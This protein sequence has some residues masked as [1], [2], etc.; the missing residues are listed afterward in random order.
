MNFKV[1][2]VRLFR[3]Y[4]PSLLEN[5]FSHLTTSRVHALL[6]LLYSY[7]GRAVVFFVH[8]HF[9]PNDLNPIILCVTTSAQMYLTRNTHIVTLRLR[10][11][12]CVCSTFITSNCV[13]PQTCYRIQ[14]RRHPRLF[15]DTFGAHAW[16]VNLS[17]M[18]VYGSIHGCRQTYPRGI[19]TGCLSLCVHSILVAYKPAVCVE[20]KVPQD[21][22]VRFS[23]TAVAA[24]WCRAL[25]CGGQ[26]VFHACTPLPCINT[27]GQ[28]RICL[29]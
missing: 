19:R 24:A 17:G 15:H 25:A 16:D 22:K 9:I 29:Y 8:R 21:T 11:V 10:H 14:P 1:L 18:H 23:H 13:L 7:K 28:R 2:N 5:T 26:H 27:H 3:R 12:Q 20:K 6:Q 4:P